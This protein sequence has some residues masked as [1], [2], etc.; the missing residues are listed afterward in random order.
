MEETKKKGPRIIGAL[1]LVLIILFF[2]IE[3]LIRE[4]QHFSPTSVTNILLFSLHVIVFLLFLILL[5]VLGRNLIKLYLERKQKVVGA[6]LKSK[7]LLFFIALSFTPTL[8]LFLFASD[9]ISRNIENLFRTPIEQILEDTKNLSEGYYVNAEDITLHY[10][11]RLSLDIVK[12]GLIDFDKKG[13][14]NDFLLEK[15]KEYQLDEIG[16]FVD[17]EELYS[18]LNSNLPLQYYQEVKKNRIK[19]AHLGEKYGTI[20]SMGN[21]ELVRR[22]I[23]T[24]L[25]DESDMLVVTGKFLPQNYS[26]RIN[27]INAYVQLYRQQKFQKNPVR[28]LYLITLIFVTLLIIFTASWI[29][30]RLA[31]GIIAPIEKLVQAT[32]E[33]SKG[34]LTVRVED[35]ASDELGMLIESFNQMI[36]D[37]QESYHNIAQ[38]TSELEAHSHYIETILNN[39]TTG[40]ITVDA[41]GVITTINPSARA[42][43]GFQDD[44]LI[45]KGY[46]DVFSRP[47]FRKIKKSIKNGLHDKFNP[48][49][50]AIDL[51]MD[52]RKSSFSLTLSPLSQNKK[53]YSGMILVLDDLTQL[54][55][56]Q[57]IA[58]WKEIAQQVA[59]EIKNPL[60]PIQLSAERIIKNLREKGG[61]DHRVISESAET[62]VQEARAIKSLVDEFSNFARLPIIRLEPADIHEVIK[63]TVSLFKDIF[64]EITFETKLSSKVPSAIQLDP[65]KM[66]RVFINILDNAIDAMDKK[67]KIKI[68]SSLDDLNKM[69]KIE[70]WDTGPGISLEDKEKLFLPHFS[71]K[72]KGAGLGLAIVH[73]IISEHNGT[74][75]VENIK[76]HGAKFIIQ[77]PT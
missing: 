17:D 24:K 50:E 43:L 57:K 14:L 62:I 56:A 38:K 21:G 77:V 74:I 70:I 20:T 22:G 40:V 34:N 48:P 45:H 15:L 51:N 35:P 25:P 23:S 47:E 75:V 55:K 19:R 6:H 29:G 11:K 41:K 26:Q 9:L 72:K 64:A 52:D 16:I 53:K 60:T 28:T 13:P 76:P 7:L 44:V 8:L 58:A 73:Q 59:H 12:K 69:V 27:N 37:L 42:M 2:G 31:K 63:G 18:V 66:K 49:N 67:G 33:V 1:I 36:S 10:A 32:K 5:F 54:I 61:K 65:E 46:E 71:T 4:G 39:V 68:Q 30:F 3:L